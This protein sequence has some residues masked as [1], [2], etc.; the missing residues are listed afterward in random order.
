MIEILNSRR[1]ILVT[2][3]FN[4]HMIT[5]NLI[6]NKIRRVK[7]RPSSTVN[8]GALGQRSTSNFAARCRPPAC[9]TA[10]GHPRHLTKVCRKRTPGIQGTLCKDVCVFYA[11]LISK[12]VSRAIFDTQL[13]YFIRKLVIL[14]QLFSTEKKLFLRAFCTQNVLHR[15]SRNTVFE[16]C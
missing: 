3:I 11:I 15:P 2:T 14:T 16:N 8:Q 1:R 13:V 12:S 6:F 4:F 5:G 7:V 10:V 9:R